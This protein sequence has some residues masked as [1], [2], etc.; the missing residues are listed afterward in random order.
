L[1]KKQLRQAKEWLSFLEDSF[2]ILKIPSNREETFKSQKEIKKTLLNWKEKIK[3][4]A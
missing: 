4:Q 3:I 1:A 2:F